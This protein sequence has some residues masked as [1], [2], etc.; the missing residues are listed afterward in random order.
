MIRIKTAEDIRGMKI[1]GEIVGWT[2]RDVLE[3]IT[4]GKTTTGELDEL[5]VRLLKEQGA[6]SSFKGFRGYPKTVCLSINEQ[7]VHGIPGRR[8]IREGDIVGLDLGASVNGFHADA[9]TTVAI[10]R[11]PES[12]RRF[13][14][15]AEE[16]LMA[17]IAQARPGNRIG[18]IGHAIQE[19]A[20]R[21]G[22]S[23]VRD[24]VGH[25]IGFA[26]HEDPQ[27]PNFGRAGEGILL[28]EG[29]TLAIEPMINVGEPDVSMLDDGWTYVTRDGRVSA[30]FEHTVAVTAE[31]PEI[32]TL[33][34]EEAP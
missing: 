30:H 25:G 19:Y 5:A 27:V 3:S 31:G 23:V 2:I 17:G 12:M 8:V 14:R 13:L 1:A 15:A 33:A 9:A 28:R 32:L 10:G 24:L 18:D 22:Y 26:L 6:K 7:V 34:L 20:E 29:M 11:A 4:P 21:R 16:S